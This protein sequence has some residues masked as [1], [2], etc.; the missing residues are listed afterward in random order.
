M[1]KKYIMHSTEPYTTEMIESFV[2]GSLDGKQKPTYKKQPLPEDWNESSVK[3][4]VYDNYNKIV[5]DKEKDVLVKYRKYFYLNTNRKR[6]YLFIKYGNWDLFQTPCFVS[7][8]IFKSP[9]ETAQKHL[10]NPQKPSAI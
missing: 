10:V 8:Y 2:Q 9:A 5:L 4:L 1:P 7:I 3:T 6:I